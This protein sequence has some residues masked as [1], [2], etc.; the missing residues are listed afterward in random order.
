MFIWF[1]LLE[2]KKKI[3]IFV[4]QIHKIQV[5]HFYITIFIHYEK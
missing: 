2:K 4:P 1:N 5:F 3:A